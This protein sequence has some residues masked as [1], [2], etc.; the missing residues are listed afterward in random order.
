MGRGGAFGSL[1]AE[2][3]REVIFVVAELAPALRGEL[4]TQHCG[5]G[6]TRLY[7]VS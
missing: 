4:E 1:P 7:L 5:G 6:K 2:S 3:V